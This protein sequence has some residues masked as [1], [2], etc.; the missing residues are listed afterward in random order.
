MRVSA[1]RGARRQDRAHRSWQGGTQ[2]PRR[3]RPSGHPFRGV[4]AAGRHARLGRLRGDGRRR[5]P[6]QAAV[7]PAPRAAQEGARRQGPTLPPLPGGGAAA[8]HQGS[9]CPFLPQLW[10]EQ[11][12][13]QHP[14]S[15]FQLCCRGHHFWRRELVLSQSTWTKYPLWDAVTQWSGLV[16]WLVPAAVVVVVEHVYSRSPTLSALGVTLT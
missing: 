10:Q 6:G 15:S 11:L 4:L 16:S 1:Q 2:A 8:A 5:S 9:H 3:R 14:E 12:Y 7:Q 13:E